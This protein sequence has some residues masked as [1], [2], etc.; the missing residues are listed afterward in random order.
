MEQ[1]DCYQNML[2]RLCKA[3]NISPRKPRFIEVEDVV[4]ITVKNHLKEGVDLECFKF[5]NLI[6]QTV[7]P[8]GIKF[9]Q[10]LLL[11]PG[12]NRLDRVTVT[13][14]KKDYIALNEKL[15]TGEIN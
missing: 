9:N 15:E 13:F 2:K 1:Q 11:Y 14:S 6:Y 12:G 5:L 8:L 3:H 4:T 10:Q 7:G